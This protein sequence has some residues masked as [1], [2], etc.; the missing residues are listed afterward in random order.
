L[1]YGLGLGCSIA[2]AGVAGPE[3]NADGELLLPKGYDQWVFV[4]AN[5]GLG[6]REEAAASPPA[7]H[8]VYMETGAYLY[9]MENAE[10][11]DPTEFLFEVYSTANKQADPEVNAGL[12]NDELEAV[13]MAVKDSKRPGHDQGAKIWAYYPFDKVDGTIQTAAAAQPDK[14]CW[15]CH[16]K[17]ADFDNVWVQFY[18]RLK[19]RLAR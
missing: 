7:F 3:Y 1:I 2:F 5:L 9:F 11:P 17:H 16:D 8:N 15:A 14:N 18:P 19:A 12:F 13:E 4:G 10:F 6:Y